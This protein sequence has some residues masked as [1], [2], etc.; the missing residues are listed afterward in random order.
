MPAVCINGGEKNCCICVA[1]ARSSRRKR[2][3]FEPGRVASVA[4]GEIAEAV[5][6]EMIEPMEAAQTASEAHVSTTDGSRHQSV[7]CYLESIGGTT[8][9]LPAGRTQQEETTSETSIVSICR[10]R[11]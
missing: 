2:A 11:V 10:A 3:R 9:P 8:S 5:V 1:I 6:A 4:A 7:R